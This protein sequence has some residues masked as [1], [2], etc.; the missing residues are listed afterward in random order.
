MDRDHELV[1]EMKNVT[2]TMKPSKSRVKQMEDIQTKAMEIF[3]DR[4][5]KYGEAFAILGLVG[6]VPSLVGDVWRIKN[7][8]YG[9]PDHGRSNK[10]DIKDKLL[11]IMNQAA[12]CYMVLSDENW[13][14]K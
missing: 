8:V 4:N 11:D 2:M 14:G 13:E 1:I 7:M 6:T 5:K 10:E 9:N 3:L 12:L